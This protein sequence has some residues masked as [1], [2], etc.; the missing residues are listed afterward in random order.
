VAQQIFYQNNDN[1][2]ML[3]GLRNQVTDTYIN[4]ATVSMTFK[5]ETGGVIT[6]PL[7]MAYVADSDGN[8]TVV[9][10]H[11]LTVEPHE[12]YTAEVTADGGADLRGFWAVPVIIEE[13]TLT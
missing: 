13:R 3:I 2:A 5:D 7:S 9:L 12:V 10:P 11:N 6:G 4:D 1:L 8:Y